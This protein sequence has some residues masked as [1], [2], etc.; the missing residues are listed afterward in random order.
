MGNITN[1]VHYTSDTDLG[2]I[3]IDLKRM[4]RAHFQKV[5]ACIDAKVNGDTGVVQFEIPLSKIDETVNTMCEFLPEYIVSV[6]GD[7]SWD[8]QLV[9]DIQPVI[10][11]TVFYG[12]LVEMC[13]QWFRDSATVTELAA[14]NLERPLRK[15]LTASDQQPDPI[16][17]TGKLEESV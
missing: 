10:D 7:I 14:K 16:A 9:T 1:N 11:E 17:P 13:M 2:H 8:G 12:I 15:D 4:R 6:S 5:T 3:Q